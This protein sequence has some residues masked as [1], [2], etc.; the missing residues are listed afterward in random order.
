MSASSGTFAT[1][2]RY[3]FPAVEGSLSTACM[4]IL[5]P[6]NTTGCFPVRISFSPGGGECLVV[7]VP[8]KSA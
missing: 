2:A 4:N 7:R 3:G 1:S 6:H 5:P 8:G